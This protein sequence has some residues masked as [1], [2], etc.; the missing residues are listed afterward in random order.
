MLTSK[1][2]QPADSGLPKINTLALTNTYIQ[3]IDD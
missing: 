1:A 2:C 3:I